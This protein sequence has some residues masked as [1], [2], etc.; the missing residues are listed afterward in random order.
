MSTN[1][2]RW[3]VEDAR[4]CHA[5]YPNARTNP[6]WVSETGRTPVQVVSSA[7]YRMPYKEPQIPEWISFWWCRMSDFFRA[8]RK[9][10]DL[11]F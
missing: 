8:I 10:V 3:H 11:A 1:G 4:T 9:L 7:P 6:S 2:E 5:K